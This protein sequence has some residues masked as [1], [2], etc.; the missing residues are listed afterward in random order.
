MRRP[1]HNN[2]AGP[3]FID[4]LT[5]DVRR[6]NEWCVLTDEEVALLN[7]GKVSAT[8]NSGEVIY[9][10]GNPCTGIYSLVQGTVGLRQADEQG[11]SAMV[12]LVHDGETF[13]YA[14][15]MGGCGY[16]ASAEA[17]TTCLVCYIDRATLSRLLDSNAEL[18]RRFQEQIVRE[19]NM[20]KEYILRQAWRPVRT[21]LAHLLLHL[22]D[23]YGVADDAG[24]IVLTPPLTRQDMADLLC[25]RPETIARTIHALE[26]DGVL[27][28]SGRTVTIPDLD[29]LLNEAGS[30]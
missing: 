24:A 18:G 5:C 25:T 22:K 7:E 28:T 2:K 17:L 11:H 29:N 27:Q 19:Y 8:Y 23:S 12:R 20:A 21:R 3:R 6:N 30:A 9:L 4:C 14:D 13:G 16:T 1:N 15:C 10:Q 26:H